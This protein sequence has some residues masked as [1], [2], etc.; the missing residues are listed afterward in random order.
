MV[1]QYYVL[2][3]HRL[4]RDFVPNNNLIHRGF[5]RA[6]GIGVQESADSARREIDLYPSELLYSI[7]RS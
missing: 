5:D 6:F 4:L 1:L 7:V 2:L 3:D